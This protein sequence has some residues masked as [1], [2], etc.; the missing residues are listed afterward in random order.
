MIYTLPFIAAII[1]WLTNYV[2]IKM[3][4]H[5]Q[6][7]KKILFFEIQGVFPKN[8]KRIADRIGSVVA[9]ELFNFD[10]I[11]DKFVTPEGMKQINRM[12]GLKVDEFL[13]VKFPDKHPIVSMFMGDKRKEELRETLMEEVDIVAPQL[14]NGYL[15]DVKE[16]V[17]IQNL[18]TTK[19][20]QFS[21]DKLEDILNAILQSELRFIEIAGAILGFIVGCI[22]V[23]ILLLA[24]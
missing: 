14:I 7:K 13:Y 8:Q 5:P 19:M 22:Q 3:L 2:A 4:F 12:I 17:D 10:D 24:G 6:E 1:G 11:K 18:V 23:G 16:K 15:D 20:E 9:N 21:S